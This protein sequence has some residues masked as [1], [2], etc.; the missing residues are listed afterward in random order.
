METNL[1]TGKR[2]YSRNA[3][4]RLLYRSGRAILDSDGMQQEKHFFQHGNT[5]CYDHSLSV[6]RM[7]I[8]LALRFRIRVD[9]DSMVRGALLHDYFL[10]DWHEWDN[11]THRLHGLTH[12]QTA[13][14]NA[15]RDFQLG[16]VERDSIARHMFPL[17]PIPP[18]YLEGY[19]VSLADKISATRETLSPTRFKRRKR[20]ARHSRRSRMS[21][22]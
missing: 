14:L 5:S 16:G 12:W 10:Y 3:V 19:I 1:G 11:G 7:A 2:R 22:A 17:T 4:A 18:K 8:F 15:S 6:A 13:L 20:Y 9:M 21:R